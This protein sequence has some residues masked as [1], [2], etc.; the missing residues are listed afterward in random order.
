[1]P[2]QA[3][4]N[5]ELKANTR[6]QA[7]ESI[8]RDGRDVPLTSYCYS[9]L[10]NSSPG[11]QLELPQLLR[12][13]KPFEAMCQARLM[14]EALCVPGHLTQCS[15]GQEASGLKETSFHRKK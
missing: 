5:A 7:H 13:W 6:L 14:Y 10:G 1:M 2:E 8:Y 9:S 15:C 3:V 4:Y 12:P 11:S